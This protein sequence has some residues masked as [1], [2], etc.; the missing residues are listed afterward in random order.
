[1]R[2]RFFLREGVESARKNEKDFSRTVQLCTH[3]LHKLGETHTH[4]TYAQKHVIGNVAKLD[5]IFFNLKHNHGN[6]EGYDK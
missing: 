5:S 4:K 2:N 1:M 3:K 6:I